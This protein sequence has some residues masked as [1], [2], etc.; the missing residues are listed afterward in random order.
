VE[1]FQ[2][3]KAYFQSQWPTLKAALESGGPAAAAGVIREHDDALERRILF[4]FCRQGINGE[5]WSGKGWDASVEMAELGIEELLAQADAEEDAELKAKRI[6]GANIISYNLSADL[7]DC[8]PGDE[9]PR[10]S[11]HFE[12][13]LKAAEDCLRW[14]EELNKPAGPRHMAWW[15]KGMHEISLGRPTDAT[16]SFGRALEFGRQMATESGAESEPGP[17]GGFAPTLSTG[18]LGLARSLA[19]DDKGDALYRQAIGGFRSQLEDE[20]RKDDAQ[21]GIEQLETVKAR[22]RS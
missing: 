6:D 18:Y 19:G 4:M 2:E 21:F 7:A 10:D 14:R 3:Q 12:R 16:E 13:G 9:E 11:R 15:A 8:W 17:E 20:A 22:Y 1:T 5:D